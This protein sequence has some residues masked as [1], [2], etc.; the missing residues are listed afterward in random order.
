MLVVYV[1]IYTYICWCIQI[2]GFLYIDTRFFK[3]WG[4]WGGRLEPF[5][6][7]FFFAGQ[8]RRGALSFQG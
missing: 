5:F 7:F 2:M 1:Y 8:S 4:G 6:F 3:S